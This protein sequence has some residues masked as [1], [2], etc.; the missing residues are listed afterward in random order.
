MHAHAHSLWGAADPRIVYRPHNQMYYLAW[1][2]CTQNCYPTRST[3]L[4]TTTNPFN[5]SAWTCHG[6]ILPGVYTGG[7]SL[8]FR[9]DGNGNGGGGGDANNTTTMV[10]LAFVSDSD[11]A[12]TLQLAQSADGIHW[13]RPPVNGSHPPRQF[14]A[15]RPG[16]WD[17]A[18]VA[19]GCVHFIPC[20]AAAAAAAAA[21]A[22]GW[23]GGWAGPADQPTACLFVVVRVGDVGVC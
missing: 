15:G 17:E 10:H 23:L 2:N 22:V 13:V 11:T 4:S 5:A 20:A 18:G 12:G 19:A 3:L 6:P 7:A 1:D 21:T 16:C 9:D 14:M 8:L